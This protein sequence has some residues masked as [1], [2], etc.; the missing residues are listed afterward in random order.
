MNTSLKAIVA[1]ICL[2]GLTVVSS[3]RPGDCSVRVSVE[4]YSCSY[5]GLSTKCSARLGISADNTDRT[6]SISVTVKFYYRTQYRTEL[7]SQTFKTFFLERGEAS[8][9]FMIQ[10]HIIPGKVD[11]YDVLAERAYCN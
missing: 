6:R 4:N 2:V 8:K 5:D 10:G 9:Q 1:V 11:V 7:T 3:A